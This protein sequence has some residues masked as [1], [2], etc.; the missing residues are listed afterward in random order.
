MQPFARGWLLVLLKI[1]LL[2]AALLGDPKAVSHLCAKLFVGA[3]PVASCK[4][5]SSQVDGLAALMQAGAIV[6][7]GSRVVDALITTPQASSSSPHQV[8]PH[9]TAAGPQSGA[10]AI[11]PSSTSAETADAS[12]KKQLVALEVDGP[13]HYVTDVSGARAGPDGASMLRNAALQA[14]GI[15]VVSVK[16]A[17]AS[18][19]ALRA[20]KFL[21]QV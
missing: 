10:T 13:S 9:H 1:A 18:F 17:A 20:P 11:D 5:L 21:A 6:G 12:G 4:L 2:L 19:E 14:W 3:A 7:D 8:A 15:N 16:V